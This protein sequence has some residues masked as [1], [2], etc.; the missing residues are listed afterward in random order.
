MAEE[1]FRIEI[2]DA[3]L[4]AKLRRLD[5]RMTNMTPFF[6]EVG[7][8]IRT[9][10]V[11]NFEEGGRYRSPGDWRGGSR[12]WRPLSSVTLF[13]QT[14]GLGGKRRK[15]GGFFKKSGGLSK[16]G[17]RRLGGKKILIDS[18]ALLNSI[19]W[20]ADRQ[21]VEIGTNRVYAAIHQF[22]GKAGR[23]HKVTIPAR[24][25]LVVQEEDL[26]QI[27]DVL[28]DYLLGLN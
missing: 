23:G 27:N 25:Y 18:G 13:G 10:V 22:G 15:G 21:G 7:E 19:N 9:S 12:K 5:E 26:D 24:P 28:E 3:D 1:N 11:K 6:Q 16:R 20:Q 14:E 2:D 4:Q 8:I 17:E